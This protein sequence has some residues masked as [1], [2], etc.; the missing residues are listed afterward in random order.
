M[1]LAPT[2]NGFRGDLSLLR[3]RFHLLGAAA[4]LALGFMVQQVLRFATSIALAWLLAPE[5]LGTMVL[6]NALRTGG[7]LLTD[8][9]IGQS[10]VRSERGDT[11]PFY[12]TAWTIQ[13]ARGLLL[14]V[15]ALLVTS[16]VAALY[17]NPAL[18]VL[19]PVSAFVFVIAG[20][21]TP[22]R[23]LWQRSV[24]AGSIVRFDVI[25]TAASSM[26]QVALA[27]I[28]PS[29]WALV[30]G[31][32][33]GAAVP[34]LA[35]FFVL[36]QKRWALRWEGPAAREIVHFGK[37]IFL[38]S[39]VYFAA[40]N[41][42]RLYFAER[43]SLAMLGLYGISRNISDMFALLFGRLS[44]QVLFPKVAGS[45]KQGGA[46]RAAMLPL[47]RVALGFVAAGLGLAV[48]LADQ[49]IFLAYDERY[50][51]AAAILPILLI[52]AWFSILAAMADSTIMGL[53][54]PA[55]VALANAAKLVVLVVLVPTA[56][57]QSGFLAAVWAFT[58]AEVLRYAV[59]T[60]VQVRCGVAFLVQDLTATLVFA[61][62]A[63]A[64]RSTFAL[65]GWTDG[66][67]ALFGSM[68]GALG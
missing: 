30:I 9:G 48:S 29:I 39:L 43:L 45:R 46:L 54:K 59:L 18:T 34:S 11:A 10:I 28:I 22:A 58:V 31:L 3:S 47:R 68:G 14:F 1:R 50:R 49:M 61:A 17:D 23:Y 12:N 66:T 19:L 13:I 21:Q 42:D 65:L 41:F 37:W 62:S 60:L 64:F 15:A 2:V 4:W 24:Q 36:R 16:P 7:E 35:S 40:S 5:L 67:A 20:L 33:V 57:L 38:S 53:G 25:T 51:A 27:I 6:I 63:W 26:L 8:I 56:L 32:L 44:D 52:S 55:G